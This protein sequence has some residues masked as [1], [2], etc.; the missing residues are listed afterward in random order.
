MANIEAEPSSVP[1]E[2]RVKYYLDNPSRYQDSTYRTDPET[3]LAAPV[4]KQFQT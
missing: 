4:Y 1:L 2:E 3:Y